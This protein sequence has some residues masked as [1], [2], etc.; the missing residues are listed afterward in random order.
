MRAQ[1]QQFVPGLEAIPP[2]RVEA[3][4]RSSTDAADLHPHAA[5]QIQFGQRLAAF[6][7]LKPGDSVTAEELKAHVRG[8]LA[9]YKVP[10]D[11]V[12]LDELPRNAVGK[13]LRRELK[14]R[15]ADT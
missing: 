13:I 7:V 5:D 6:V 15:L 3:A 11:I 1:H 2:A 12:V 9:N 4:V 8:E 10:R 14:A